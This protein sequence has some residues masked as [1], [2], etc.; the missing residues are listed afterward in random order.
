MSYIVRN[1]GHLSKQIKEMLKADSCWH[2]KKIFFSDCLVSY[3]LWYGM[4]FAHINFSLPNEKIHEV[5][6]GLS[7]RKHS[8]C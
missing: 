1:M 8:H 2:N 5:G 7:I 6:S 3:L 4:M